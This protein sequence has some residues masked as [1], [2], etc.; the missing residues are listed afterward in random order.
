MSGMSNASAAAAAFSTPAFYQDPYATY[1]ALL[2]AGNVQDA[3]TR[4]FES[5]GERWDDERC[6]LVTL[7]PGE[8]W[9]ADEE[10]V[11]DA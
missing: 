5:T 9:I 4:Y 1:R 8:Y 3:V 7:S 10:K 2:D 6:E 11:V